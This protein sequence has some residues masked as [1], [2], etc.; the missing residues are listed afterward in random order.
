MQGENSLIA[1]GS[2]RVRGSKNDKSMKGIT[3]LLDYYRPDVVVLPDVNAKAVRRATRIKVLNRLAV[4]LANS[5]RIKLVIVS[6]KRM[7]TTL[8]NDPKGTKH[9]MA[10][11]VAAQFPNQLGSLLPAKRRAWEGESANMDMFDAVGLLVA[12]CKRQ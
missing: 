4:G 12:V 9:Q 1:F 8:L 5:R 11:A 3:K 7:R 2:K 6:G 10:A